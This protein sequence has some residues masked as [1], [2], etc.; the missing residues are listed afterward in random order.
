MPK[1]CPNCGERILDKVK[2]C[3]ECGVDIDSFIKKS[4]E[5]SISEEKAKEIQNG[6]V[7]IENTKN[8]EL[9]LENNTGKKDVFLS[10]GSS[11]FIPSLGQIYNGQFIKGLGIGLLILILIFISKPLALLVWLIGIID[12][13]SD[14]KRMNSGKL[15]S[16][17]I[18]IGYIIIYGILAALI[19]WGSLLGSNAVPSSSTGSSIGQ[20]YQTSSA[21]IVP[22]ITV[23]SQ[24]DR[25]IRIANEIVAD[26]HK[27]HTYSLNDFYVCGDMASDV[28]DMLKTQGINAKLNVGRV[29][30]DITNIK[31]ANHVWVLAEVAP[32]QYLALEATGGYSVQQA[33]NP[34][35]YKGWSFYSPKQLKN[36]MDLSKEYNDAVLKYNL[37]L[38]DYNGIVSQ[39]N[40]AGFLT[41]LSLSSQLD[42]KK[43]ILN[44]RTQDLNQITN[45]INALLSSL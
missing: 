22:M 13:Y 40:N 31:D 44:Q 5:P 17:S 29:D 14:S 28:W 34:R 7:K 16:K 38:N 41:R 35:Y 26:Y 6:K 45:Q 2:F 11:F 32:D 10:I 23:E 20:Q 25:N 27:T 43:L 33:D 21:Q 4:D 37:A 30:Q 42:D 18:D 36:Y 8:K 12:A 3:P 24:N 9:P 15:P 1:F 39:Y 19:I